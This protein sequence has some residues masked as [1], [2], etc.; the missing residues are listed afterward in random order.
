MNDAKIASGRDGPVKP[1]KVILPYEDSNPENEP[2]FV[3]HFEILQHGTDLYI[4]AGVL[5][6]DDLAQGAREEQPRFLVLQRLAMSVNTFAALLRTAGDVFGRLNSTEFLHETLK[7]KKVQ[8]R[9]A[10]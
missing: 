5:P 2:L 8:A 6:A 3:N 4:D 9:K 7:S 1:K 10:R